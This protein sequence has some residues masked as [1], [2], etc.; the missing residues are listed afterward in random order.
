MRQKRIV[1]ETRLRLDAEEWP[2]ELTLT[3]RDE[4]GFRMLLGRHAIKRRYV[5][6][7]GTSY[8]MGRPEQDETA[9]KRSRRKPRR[10]KRTK[11]RPERTS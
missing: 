4:M 3:N 9:I 7:P 1:V 6:D 10:R 5:V 11:R 2:I 8:R